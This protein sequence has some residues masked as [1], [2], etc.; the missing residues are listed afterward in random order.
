MSMIDN[1]LAVCMYVAHGILSKTGLV[2][3]TSSERS[4]SLSFQKITLLDQRN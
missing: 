4:L 3:N 2:F 1:C